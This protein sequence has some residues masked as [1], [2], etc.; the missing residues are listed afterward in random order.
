MAKT[1]PKLKL[2]AYALIVLLLLFGLLQVMSTG[3][4][5]FLMLEA[6]GFVV[7]LVLSLAGFVGY[8]RRWGKLLLFLVFLFYLCNLILIWYFK[9]LLYLTLLVLAVMGFVLNLLPSARKSPQKHK[10]EE[11]HS[12]VFDEPV[13]KEEKVPA[14][15]KEMRAEVKFSPGKYVASKNSNVYHEPKCDWAKK[16]MKDR[17][18]WFADRKAA[19]DKGYKK[20]S[21][22]A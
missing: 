11:L 2:V 7:L 13:N 16:I 22:V 18:V 9:D 20:H 3:K 4:G 21:C 10:A 6:I 12:M 5:T 14:P 15:V 1:T 17:Q 8:T 19:L